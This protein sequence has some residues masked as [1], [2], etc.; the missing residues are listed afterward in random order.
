MELPSNLHEMDR[1]VRIAF[2]I[3][4]DLIAVFAPLAVGLKILFVLLAALGIG[5]GVL[6]FCPVY[7]VLGISTCQGRSKNVPLGGVKVYHL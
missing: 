2:G 7:K 6:N 1:K 5:T 4:F 3:I